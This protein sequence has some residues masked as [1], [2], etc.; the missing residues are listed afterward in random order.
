MK[1]EIWSDVVCPWCYIGKRRFESALGQFA[2]RDDV[3]VVWRSFELDP[4]SQ[5]R[6][7]GT[8]DELLARKL[9]RSTEQ[10]AAMNA[11]VSALAAKE[12]LD[13]HLDRAQHGNTFDAHRLIHLA[14]RHGLQ[15]EAKERLLKAYFTEGAAIGDAE[16]LAALADELGLPADEVRETLAG[17]AFADEVRADERRAQALGI[18]GVPAFVINERYLISGAQEPQVL[19]SALEQIWAESHP[20]TPLATPAGAGMCD[21]ESCAV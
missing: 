17:T 7:P 2:H 15:A 18:S 9:G 21:D 20:L 16:A 4:G 10:A 6:S 14:E 5:R 3:Q 1:I 8:L 19:L 13:Y 11:H 12:G